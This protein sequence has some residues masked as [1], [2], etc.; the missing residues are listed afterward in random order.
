MVVHR[1]LVIHYAFS[2]SNVFDFCNETIVVKDFSAKIK[3][4]LYITD[5]CVYVI[6]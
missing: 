6:Y 4:M 2:K 1:T 5:K 3:K